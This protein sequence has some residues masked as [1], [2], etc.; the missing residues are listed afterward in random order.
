M[1]IIIAEW[2]P[3]LLSFKAKIQNP[4]CA[5]E[6]DNELDLASVWSQFVA[7]VLCKSKRS[8]TSNSNYSL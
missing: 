4:S 2:L 5:A 7:N 3:F 1:R 6:I 8:V